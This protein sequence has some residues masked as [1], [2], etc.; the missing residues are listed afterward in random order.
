MEVSSDSNKDE[1][2]RPVGINVKTGDKEREG[3]WSSTHPEG[4]G[5][6]PKRN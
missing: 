6:F 5:S 1:F 4:I 3:S 2:V